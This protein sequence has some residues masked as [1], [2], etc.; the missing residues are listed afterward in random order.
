MLLN[1]CPHVLL[2]SSYFVGAHET[3]HVQTDL[4]YTIYPLNQRSATKDYFLLFCFFNN[5][6]IILSTTAQEVGKD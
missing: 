4:I 1:Y 6:L 2:T 5:Q 3:A